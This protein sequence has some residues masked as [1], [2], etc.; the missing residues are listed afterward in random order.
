MA[1]REHNGMRVDD[2][3]GELVHTYTNFESVRTKAVRPWIKV[4]L[5]AWATLKNVKGFSDVT[6][7]V[8]YQILCLYPEAVRRAKV[9][10]DASGRYVKPVVTPSVEDK[11]FWADVLGTQLPVINNSISKLVKMGILM[12]EKRG[13]YLVNPE[14][15]GCGPEQDM[16]RLRS[17]TATFTISEN[18][19][20]ITPTLDMEPDAEQGE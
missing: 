2:E 10:T 16:E 5:D 3:T 1:I 9:R 20:T 4:Y 7:E 11:R 13:A 6:C 14:L 19:A 12:R 17:I 15:I 8:L 18:G